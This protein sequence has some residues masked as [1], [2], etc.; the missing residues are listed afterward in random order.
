MVQPPTVCTPFC[1]VSMPLMQMSWLL[2]KTMF[3][4]VGFFVCCVWYYLSLQFRHKLNYFSF[5]RTF[6]ILF[7][8]CVQILIKY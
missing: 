6:E 5:C 8:I 2:H 1:R 4:G 7:I 3:V